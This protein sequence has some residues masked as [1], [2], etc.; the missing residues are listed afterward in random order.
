MGAGSIPATTLSQSG[1]GINGNEGV[2]HIPQNSRIG[3]S[4]LDAVSCHT[5][6]TKNGFMRS[7]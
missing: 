1:Y 2:L 5:Q 7:E 6:S 4:P 3:A